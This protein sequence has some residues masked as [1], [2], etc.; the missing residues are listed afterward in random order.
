MICRHV[1]T[2][3]LLSVFVI[4][5]STVNAHAQKADD[6]CST[7]PFTTPKPTA[8][9]VTITL[10]WKALHECIA[11]KKGI[12]N[13][14]W[15]DSPNSLSDYPGTI[16]SDAQKASTETEPRPRKISPALHCK[17]KVLLT[18]VDDERNPTQDTSSLMC[19][20]RCTQ[21]SVCWLF[22]RQEGFEHVCLA[23]CFAR[24]RNS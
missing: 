15:P 2:S 20:C 8:G 6:V 23:S 13:R 21:A 7:P 18:I 12:G 22:G 1:A 11:A 3:A 24:V 9:V 14:I 17:P 10:D 19:V 16:H 4:L 5:G